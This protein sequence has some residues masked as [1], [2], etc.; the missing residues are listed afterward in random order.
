MLLSVLSL[1]AFRAEKPWGT[2]SL[3]VKII[4]KWQRTLLFFDVRCKIVAVRCWRRLLSFQLFPRGPPWQLEE[5][6]SPWQRPHRTPTPCFWLASSSSSSSQLF[7]PRNR[8]SQQPQ[9]RLCSTHW[10]NQS[11]RRKNIQ[12]FPSKVWHY[13]R[14]IFLPSASCKV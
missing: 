8:L 6:S 14:N 7:T 1:A 5:R 4:L 12:R 10:P 3:R 2:E 13:S 9:A 11:V